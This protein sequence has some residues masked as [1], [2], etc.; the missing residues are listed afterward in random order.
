MTT[1]HDELFELP[2]LNIDDYDLDDRDIKAAAA[3]LERGFTPRKA[4]HKTKTYQEIADELCISRETLHKIRMKPDFQ[5]YVRDMSH[6]MVLDKTPM[7]VER[8]MEMAL[9]SN[10]QQP[11]L[12]A[13]LAAL[14]MG[15]MYKAKGS[16]VTVNVAQQD[17]AYVSEA[18]LAAIAERYGAGE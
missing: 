7:L 10:A 6:A 14:E 8:L 17:K 9:G 1:T 11:G 12:K 3:V 2:A 16:E 5:R 18:E 15:G 13:I 4:S